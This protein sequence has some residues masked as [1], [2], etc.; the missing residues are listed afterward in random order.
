MHFLKAPENTGLLESEIKLMT[1]DID[2]ILKNFKDNHIELSEFLVPT[3][4]EPGKFN[5]LQK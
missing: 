3:S 1:L 2:E 4:T 5:V